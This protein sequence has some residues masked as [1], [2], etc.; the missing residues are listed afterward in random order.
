MTEY[1]WEPIRGLPGHLPPGEDML[2]QGA[3]DWTVLLRTAFAGR[4]VAVYFALLAITGV[5]S[6]SV[7]GAAITI[8]MGALGVAVLALLAWATARSTVYT[9]TSRRIVFRIGVALPKCFNLPLKLIEAAD[10]RPVG[11]T[12][13]DIALTIGGED[14]IAYLLLWPHARPW[15]LKRPVPMMRAL[16]DAAAVAARLARACAALTPIELAGSPV[17]A[18]AADAPIPMGVAA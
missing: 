6:G 9:L 7:T 17:Q 15:Q 1:E 2:W 11:D 18:P 8:G 4:L 14:H 16:P 12:H 3:P 13:G 10:L 5:L